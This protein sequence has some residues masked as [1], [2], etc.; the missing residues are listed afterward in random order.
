MLIVTWFVIAPLLPT[1]E[2]EDFDFDNGFDTP[3]IY[4]GPPTLK[5]E[6]AW[7]RLIRSRLKDV[8]AT[9]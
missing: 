2:Y 4:R 9:V 6:A 8:V 3:S 1:L 5:I 7:D